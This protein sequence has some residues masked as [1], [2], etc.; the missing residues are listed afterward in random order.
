MSRKIYAPKT[1]ITD[2]RSAEEYC[3]TCS[4]FNPY[5]AEDGSPGQCWRFP[6]VGKDDERTEI[7]RPKAVCCGEYRPY[8][9]S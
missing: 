7:T 6:P 9:V 2:I 8:E 4:W 1:G 3:E 5:E